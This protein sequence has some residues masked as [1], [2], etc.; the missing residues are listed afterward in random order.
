[1]KKIVIL[2]TIIIAMQI[3]FLLFSRSFKC[4]FSQVVQLINYLFAAVYFF[5]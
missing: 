5:D 2:T 4:N 1:M 3:K